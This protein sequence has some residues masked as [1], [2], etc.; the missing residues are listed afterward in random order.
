ML[1]FHLFSGDPYAGGLDYKKSY[2]NIDDAKKDD[3]AC[4]HQNQYIDF[5]DG[6]RLIY[7][8]QDDGSLKAVA[9][10]GFSSIDWIDVR[11]T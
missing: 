2:A 8:T 1:R 10:M 7:E 11:Q 3:E 6:Y 5:V 9:E 4:R